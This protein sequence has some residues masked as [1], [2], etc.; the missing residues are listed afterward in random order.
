[1]ELGTKNLILNPQMT[2]WI[3]TC[4]FRFSIANLQFEAVGAELDENWQSEIENFHF[5]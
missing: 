3:G 4:N 5:C 2:M 1:M